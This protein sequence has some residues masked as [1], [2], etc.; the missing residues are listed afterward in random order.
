MHTI[1]MALCFVVY[2]CWMVPGLIILIVFSMIFF[3]RVIG[4]VEKSVLELKRE[5]NNAMSP[6]M[7]NLTEISHARQLIQLMG[8]DGVFL[9]RHVQ[10]MNNYLRLTFVTQSVQNWTK[11]IGGYLATLIGA[12]SVALVL[13]AGSNDTDPEIRA[14]QIGINV[15]YTL[16]IPSL[17]AFIFY[18][19]SETKN[20]LALTDFSFVYRK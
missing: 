18:M 14:G 10:Y 7:T 3:S 6:L 15:A 8:Y 2:M 9:G 1:M 19:V 12:V 11:M 5:T 20:Y 17:I 13:F 16:T 4:A